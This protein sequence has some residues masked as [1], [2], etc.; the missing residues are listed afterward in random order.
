MHKK[1]CKLKDNKE[2]LKYHVKYQRRYE[3]FPQQSDRIYYAE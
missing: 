2:W 1:S 3:L